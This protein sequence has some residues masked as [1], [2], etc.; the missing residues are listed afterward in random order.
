M[1][2]TVVKLAEPLVSYQLDTSELV[3]LIQ[4]SAVQHLTTF[5]QLQAEKIGSVTTIVT[6]D[7]EALYAYKRGDYH[8]DVCSFLASMYARWLLAK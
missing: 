3:E 2:D 7:F 1:L 4:K 5:R 6:T 8:C